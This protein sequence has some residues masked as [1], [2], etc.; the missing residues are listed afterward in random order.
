MV[1]CL[2][3]GADAL[4][5]GREGRASLELVTALYESIASGQEVRLPLKVE[6]S[7]LGRG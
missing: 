1:D 7:R 3:T 2:N 6:H 5:D 4:V